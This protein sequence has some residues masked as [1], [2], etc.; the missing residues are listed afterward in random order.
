M[1]SFQCGE[2]V[3]VRFYDEP[4]IYGPIETIKFGPNGEWD[5]EVNGVFYEG[6]SVRKLNAVERGE[7]LPD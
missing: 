5:I 2:V 3:C 6:E 1:N 7:E 4:N